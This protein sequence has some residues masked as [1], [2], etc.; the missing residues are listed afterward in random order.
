MGLLYNAPEVK[1]VCV[2]VTISSRHMEVTPA[3]KSF[4]EQKTAK[5]T[6]YYDRIQ[7]IEV[8]FDNA[9]EA[10][11]VEMIV[12]AEHRKM[13]IAHHAEGD[14]YA[15]VDGCT[16]KLERQLSEYKKKFRNRK[17]STGEDKHEMRSPAARA[18]TAKTTGQK[19]NSKKP[20]E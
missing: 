10:M 16:A 8:I 17:H 9:S 15:C 11:R 4:A 7:E 20:R 1:E 19:A 2:L 3:L 13:F 6:R 12:N 5:L 14:A 18:V